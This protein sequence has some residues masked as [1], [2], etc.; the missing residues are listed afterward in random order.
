LRDLQ[1]RVNNPAGADSLGGGVEL[2]ARSKR[3]SD[4]SLK[5]RGEWL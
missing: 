5:M 3:G 2:S 4:N 1:G